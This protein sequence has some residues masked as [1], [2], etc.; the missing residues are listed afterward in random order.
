MLKYTL[1]YLVLT[2]IFGALG[3]ALVE[4]G[5]GAAIAK[6]LFSMFLVLLLGS[7]LYRPERRHSEI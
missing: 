1:S 3:F 5:T 2:V 4:G 7:V 6:V